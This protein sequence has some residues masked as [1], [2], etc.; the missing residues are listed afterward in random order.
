MPLGLEGAMLSDAGRMRASNEDCAAYVLPRPDDP[1]DRRCALVVVADGMGGHAAGEVASRLAC[2]TVV[3]VL[4]QGDAGPRPLLREA[5]G[6]ANAAILARSATDPGLHGLGTTLTA[7]VVRDGK[8]WLGHVGD[9]RAYLLRDDCLRQLSDD[10]SL[11]G[12]MVRRG[13]LSSA[14]ARAHPERH[15]I[16]KALGTRPDLEPTIW[17]AGLA[18]AAGDVL[19]VCSDGLTDLVPDE[20]ITASLRRHEPLDACRALLRAALAA[21]GHDNVTVGVFR[22][23]AAQAREPGLAPTTRVPAGEAP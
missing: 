5:L 11:V 15:V 2:E 18:L 21:G 10:H 8:A 14:A 23:V 19:L 12:E 4:S 17:R 1:A 13:E 7:L 6:T 3:R 16:V 9:S 20:A 22:V